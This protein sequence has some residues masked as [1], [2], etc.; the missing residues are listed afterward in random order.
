MA[1]FS[2]VT[3][4]AINSPTKKHLASKGDEERSYVE[5]QGIHAALAEAVATVVREKPANALGRIADILGAKAGTAVLPPATADYLST[6]GNTPMVQLSKMLPE[7]CKAKVYVK[8]EMQNPG[9]SIKDRI[10]KNMLEEAEAAGKLKPG[11]TVVE[12]TSGNTGIGLAMACAAKG[13]KC[14]IMMPQ[15]PAMFERYIVARQFGAEV[16]LTAPAKGFAGLIDAFSELVASDPLTYFG[17]NQFYNEDNPA[18]HYATTGPEI[19]TQTGGE[20]DYFVHGVG[21]GGTIS[22]AGKYLKEKKSSV[23]VVAIEPSNSRVH[24]GEAPSGPHSIVGIGAGVKTHFLGATEDSTFVDPSIVDE[25]AHASSE[26]AIAYAAK[27][28]QEEGMMVGPS[29]GAALKVACDLAVK[30][31]CA[32]KTIVVM[33]ASH[34]IR[35]VNHPM[36]AAVKKEATLALP[37]PPNMDKE[38]ETVLWKS[39]EYTP[40]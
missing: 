23:K 33:Q 37:A 27:A 15:T 9:G 6:I 2:N 22:G 38:C 26:E 40:E 17:A 29:A 3:S 18:T 21:T 14:I 31:E 5:N 1:P 36:W 4:E 16:I 25:W 12:G 39:S 34:G 28:C 32:G 20:V 30:E 8:L 19:W 35:Y 7:G 11:M 24:M 10:A 13:Y